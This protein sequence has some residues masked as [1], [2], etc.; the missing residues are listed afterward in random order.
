ML[1]S[2]G[3]VHSNEQIT[4]D[5]LFCVDIA[6]QDN[7]VG[8]LLFCVACDRC[9]ALATVHSNTH[10]FAQCITH[11]NT[12]ETDRHGAAVLPNPAGCTKSMWS[13]H[14]IF[15]TAADAL[16]LPVSTSSTMDTGCKF[17]L[18]LNMHAQLTWFCMLRYVMSVMSVFRW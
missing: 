14:C 9:F 15:L 12:P 4:S 1:W 18:S 13:V 3:I 8:M 6:L 17:C 16:F 7:K 11:L 5:G 2:L 10:M